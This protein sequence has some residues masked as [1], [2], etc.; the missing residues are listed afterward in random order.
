HRPDA[1]HLDAGRVHRDDDH[2]DALMLARLG[3]GPDGHPVVGGGV[4]ARVP[5]LLP[6]DHP[7]VAVELGARREPGQIGARIGLRVRDGEV[8]LAT[9]DGRP[10]PRLL[11]LGALAQDG[12]RHRGDREVHRWRARALHLL[13]EDVLLDRGLPEAAELLWPAHAPPAPLEERAVE[14]PGQRTV[15]LVACLTQLGA[16]LVGDVRLAERMDFVAPCAL[17]WGVLVPH[18]GDVSMTK[19]PGVA[20]SDAA[21][22]ALRPTK[23]RGRDPS[24]A[25]CRSRAP[26]CP[27]S[28][29]WRAS[30]VSRGP[31]S[32]CLPFLLR[33]RRPSLPTCATRPRTPSSS[34]RPPARKAATTRSSPSWPV[35]R[36]SAPGSIAPR[37]STTCSSRT[38]PSRAP[39]SSGW[40]G[41]RSARAASPTPPSLSPPRPALAP[42]R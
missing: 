20:R 18:R 16:Q 5:D 17:R 41:R 14:L 27:P 7:L 3:L 40:G 35:T 37:A 15:A 33:R 25:S 32:R 36:R 30:W 13:D 6:V 26:S 39:P 29:P 22:R 9:Q 2:R 4:R 1:L 31:R 12:G 24:A 11:L 19:D 23:A 10:P 38:V 21:F 34:S 28:L 8:D 42:G